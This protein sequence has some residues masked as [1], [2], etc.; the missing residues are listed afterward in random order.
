MM[1]LNK[2]TFLGYQNTDLIHFVFLECDCDDD[3]DDDDCDCKF[4]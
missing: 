1:T 3:D 4:G 2:I